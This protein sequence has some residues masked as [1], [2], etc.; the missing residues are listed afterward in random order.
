MKF[1]NICV[2]VSM[3]KDVDML[4]YF[5]K[6]QERWVFSEF[7]ENEALFYRKKTDQESHL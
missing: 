3:E 6:N 2:L 1:L 5:N 7:F 4:M